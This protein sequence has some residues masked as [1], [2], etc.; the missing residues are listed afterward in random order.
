M[1]LT[2]LDPASTDCFRIAAPA[3]SVEGPL[4]R[5]CTFVCNAPAHEPESFLVSRL[6][7]WLAGSYRDPTPGIEDVAHAGRESLLL[8]RIHC[9]G[10]NRFILFFIPRVAVQGRYES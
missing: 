8:D 6:R 3:L 1:S 2:T 4:Q 9:P 5:L 10:F 7:P